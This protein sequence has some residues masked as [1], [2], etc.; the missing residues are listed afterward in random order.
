MY[1]GGLGCFVLRFVNV[2]HYDHYIIIHQL[3]E[4]YSSSVQKG[5]GVGTTEITT[6]GMMNSTGCVS[7]TEIPQ[8]LTSKQNAICPDMQRYHGTIAT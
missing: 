2:N 5:Y 7:T 1:C 8:A 3:V 6:S 4:Q